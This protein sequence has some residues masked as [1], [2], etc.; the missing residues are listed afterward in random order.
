MNL[1]DMREMGV[2]GILIYCA[3]YQC[4]HS[5]A[6]SADRWSDEVRL[7][8]IEPRF[9][10]ATCGKRGAEVR[11]DF[12]WNR[13]VV[14]RLVFEIRDN[15]EVQRGP[16]MISSRLLIAVL[17]TVGLASAPFAA[18]GKKYKHVPTQPKPGMATTPPRTTYGTMGT[19]AG[20]V[21]APSVG[22]YYKPSVGVTNTVPTWSNTNPP[23]R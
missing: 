6:L 17:V 5:V 11:P 2:R 9:V 15:P 12:N 22:S 14:E 4:S 7:S 21:T 1:G 8:D 23:A 18:E 10:C 13:R 3:D 20:T 16:T 19:S